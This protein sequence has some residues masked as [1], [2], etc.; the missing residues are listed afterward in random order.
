M[1]RQN[2]GFSNRKCKDKI[3][4][5]VFQVFIFMLWI[6]CIVFNSWFYFYVLQRLRVE[7]RDETNSNF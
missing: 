6:D 1:C 4:K 3:K 5:R 7:I 2:V